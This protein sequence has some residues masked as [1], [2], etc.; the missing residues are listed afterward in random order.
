MDD[1]VEPDNETKNLL[2]LDILERAHVVTAS[3]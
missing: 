1:I 2:L 3:L